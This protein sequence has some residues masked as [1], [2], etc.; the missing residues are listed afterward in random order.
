[1]SGADQGARGQWPRHVVPTTAA[2]HWARARA[3]LD[4]VEAAAT[5]GDHKG[6]KDASS[7]LYLAVVDVRARARLGLLPA[8]AATL[9]DARVLDVESTTNATSGG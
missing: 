3:F 2:E 5:R 7:D 6:A 4:E 9:G 1:M 8:A